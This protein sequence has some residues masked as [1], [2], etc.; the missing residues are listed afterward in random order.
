M[1]NRYVYLKD[2]LEY[3]LA[4]EGA[5]AKTD[6]P[7]FTPYCLYSGHIMTP[8]QMEERRQEQVKDLAAQGLDMSACLLYTSPSP[9]D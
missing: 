3:P 6:V 8:S 1:D 7:P 5:H 2:S 9:R 4:G